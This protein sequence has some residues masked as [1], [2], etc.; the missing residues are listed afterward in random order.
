MC[1]SRYSN[2]L[3]MAASFALTS[4]GRCSSPS[5][6]GIGLIGGGGR[7]RC[8]EGCATRASGG[9]QSALWREGGLGRC[10]VARARSAMACASLLASRHVLLARRGDG[11]LPC[12]SVSPL[13]TNRR[14]SFCHGIRPPLPSAS[15]SA[16]WSTIHQ[17][18][19]DRSGPCRTSCCIALS[20]RLLVFMRVR[21]VRLGAN[22]PRKTW[23]A[24]I[25]FWSGFAR[26]LHELSTP[27]ERGLHGLCT[28]KMGFPYTI[29]PVVQGNS[30]LRGSG[31]LAA[32]VRPSLG[33]APFNQRSASW[34]RTRRNC[35]PG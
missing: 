14:Q 16:W 24:Q 10:A 28:T 6:G 27:F 31:T 26:P 2:W 3:S 33:D 30:L 18:S 25:L 32:F 20:S 17:Y 11:G 35:W 7:V 1:R 22:E 5:R 9:C 23:L 21:I 19:V 15:S 29:A 34:R 8:V 12:P 4:A 13:A